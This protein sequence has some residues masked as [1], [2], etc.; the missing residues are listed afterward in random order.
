MRVSVKRNKDIL[1]LYL[2]GELD[3]AVAGELRR[4]ID[5]LLDGGEA[6]KN[7]VLNME[8]LTFMDS[9]GVGLIMGRYKKLKQDN[10]GLFIDK[11][12]AQ[13]DKVLRVSGLYGIIPKL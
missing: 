9:T 1:Y 8:R 11:P 6:V 10:V 7:V 4:K 13:I 5:E 2:D 3:H 12:N